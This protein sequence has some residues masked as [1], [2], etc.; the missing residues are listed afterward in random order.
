MR[1]NYLALGKADEA[2]KA[3]LIG[4]VLFLALIA[5]LPFIPDGFPN[6]AIPMMYSVLAT[7]IAISTQ[8]GKDEITQSEQYRL[9]SNWGVFGLGILTMVAS[10]VVMMAVFWGMESAGFISLDE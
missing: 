4:A 7:K 5:V 9:A 3:L 2:Q 6:P 8:P 1:S 10:M